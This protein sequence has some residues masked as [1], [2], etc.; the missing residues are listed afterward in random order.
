MKIKEPRQNSVLDKITKKITLGTISYLTPRRVSFALISLSAASLISK[1]IKGEYLET[2]F[3][4]IEKASKILKIYV[5]D[6]ILVFPNYAVRWLWGDETLN[7]I[8]K[9]KN[10]YKTLKDTIKEDS[11]KCPKEV[12]DK[13]VSFVPESLKKKAG[14]YNKKNYL[15]LRKNIFSLA[16]MAVQAA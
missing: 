14:L 16:R 2:K 1:T 3:L 15:R 7:K 8:V 11:F 5:S 10:T 12:I 4:N 13:I 6:D 9:I